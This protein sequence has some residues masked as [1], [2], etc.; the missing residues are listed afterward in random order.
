[1]RPKIKNIYQA[2]VV[3]KASA[4]KIDESSEELFTSVDE[5]R[6]RRLEAFKK[7]TPK[8][9]PKVVLNNIDEKAALNDPSFWN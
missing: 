4:V 5:I 2:D 6:K 7:P 9:K 1:M 3:E 8:P